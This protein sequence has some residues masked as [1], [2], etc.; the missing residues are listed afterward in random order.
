MSGARADARVR[1]GPRGYRPGPLAATL[2]LACLAAGPSLAAD[3]GESTDRSAERTKDRDTRSDSRRRVEDATKKWVEQI[4][5]EDRRRR[6]E[7]RR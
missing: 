7:K 3:A 5:E 6:A 4:Q 2:L 1:Y